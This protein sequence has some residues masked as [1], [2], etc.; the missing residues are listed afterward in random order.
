MFNIDILECSN[1]AGAR[2]FLKLFVETSD[3]S[4]FSAHLTAVIDIQLEDG[5]GFKDAY[6]WPPKDVVINTNTIFS[7]EE[8]LSLKESNL[9][10]YEAPDEN[11][12]FQTFRD[13]MCAFINT[14]WEKIEIKVTFDG[15]NR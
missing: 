4:L 14:L 11:T 10:E 15:N 12:V 13:E 9:N 2:V 8:I 3:P 1:D 5:F 7:A 6:T